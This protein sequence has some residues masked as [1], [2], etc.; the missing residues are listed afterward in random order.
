MDFDDLLAP[1]AGDVVHRAPGF[2][3]PIQDQQ[4]QR[5]LPQYQPPPLTPARARADDRPAPVSAV[6]R[7]STGRE[8]LG[9]TWNATG[10]VPRHRRVILAGASCILPSAA[11]VIKAGTGHSRI[12]HVTLI[13]IL[14]LCL[15]MTVQTSHHHE[16]NY[17]TK[18]TLKRNAKE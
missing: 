9:P 1:D 8:I 17:R 7:T 10:S 15:D 2:P 4:H 16:R 18:H 13:I 5:C 12:H 3:I 14:L 11:E 6:L